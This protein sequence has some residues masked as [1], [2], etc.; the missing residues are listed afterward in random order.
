MPASFAPLLS[1][2]IF[3][4]HPCAPIAFWKK[5]LAAGLLF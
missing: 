1:S 2:V 3:S 5:A 4:G